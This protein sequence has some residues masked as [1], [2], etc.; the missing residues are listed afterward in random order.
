MYLQQLHVCFGQFERPVF[1]VV[2]ELVHCVTTDGQV[3]SAGK[4]DKNT[5]PH[6]VIEKRVDLNWNDP[7]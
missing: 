4:N 3:E 1:G 6:K 2:I 5:T 7:I